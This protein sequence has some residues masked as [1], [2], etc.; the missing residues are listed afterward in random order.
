MLLKSLIH[1]TDRSR[2]V[3]RDTFVIET[4]AMYLVSEIKHTSEFV[5]IIKF[6]L[7]GK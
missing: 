4:Y 1:E 5:V 6:V 2:Y 3:V 7:E